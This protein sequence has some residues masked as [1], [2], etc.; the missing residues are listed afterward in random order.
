MKN[1]RASG[2]T[3]MLFTIFLF[4]VKPVQ[5][6]KYNE[7]RLKHGHTAFT[8][9]GTTLIID[10]TEYG[11][12]AELLFFNTNCIVLGRGK[13]IE[14]LVTSTDFDPNMIP[15]RFRRRFDRIQIVTLMKMKGDSDSRDTLTFLPTWLLTLPKLKAL[16]LNNF[17]VSDSS[18]IGDLMIRYLILKDCQID[19]MEKFVTKISRN[20]SLNFLIHKDIFRNDDIGLIMTNAPKIKVISTVDA[21]IGIE[22]EGVNYAIRMSN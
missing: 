11:S 4:A 1:F 12:Q 2:L 10:L 21:V 3:F 22:K 7:I 19:D 9:N 20:V 5:S 6:Q 18:P 16:E 13:E 17:V 8:K 15:I 14:W